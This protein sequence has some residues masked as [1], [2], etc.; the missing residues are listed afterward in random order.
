MLWIRIQNPQG[1]ETFRRAALKFSDPDL[2]QVYIMKFALL[3]Y[4]VSIL[5]VSLQSLLQGREKPR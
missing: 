1:S 5:K 4:T 2:G 3:N